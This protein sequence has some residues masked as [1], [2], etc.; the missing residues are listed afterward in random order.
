MPR[1]EA[2]GGRVKL[3]A[4]WLIEAAGFTKGYARG[5]A[6]ISS[7]HALALV[8]GG[9]ATAADITAL[10]REI[11]DRVAARFGVRLAAEPVFVGLEL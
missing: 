10:A 3:S 9:A 5:E 6:R 2:G 4:A 11:R 7:R 1:Y 8:N